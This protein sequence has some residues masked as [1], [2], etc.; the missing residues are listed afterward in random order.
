MTKLWIIYTT[1]LKMQH[2][3]LLRFCYKKTSRM[4]SHSG[5]YFPELIRYLDLI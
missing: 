4:E 3:F 1:H 2:S 5:H